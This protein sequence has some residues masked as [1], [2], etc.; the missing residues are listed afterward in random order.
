[1]LKRK[2]W[3]VVELEIL[4]RYYPDMITRAIADALG[5]TERQVYSKAASLGLKKSAEYLAGP[6]ACRLRRGDNVGAATRFKK[7]QT[8]WN[9]GKPG[10]TG[11]HPNSRRTQFKKGSMSGA[12]QHNYVPI[13]SLRITKDGYLERK[14]TDDPNLYPA[15]RWV[16]LHRLV[17]EE[18]HGP[19]PAGHLVVFRPGMKTTEPGEVTLDRL[20]CI[21][22]AENMRRNSYH[23]YPKEI[24]QAIQMR[25]ALNRKI[26]NVEKHQRSA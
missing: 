7:G 9:K 1:M 12:A 23:N 22:R 8:P 6:H 19:V 18:A 25:G 24:A 11:S 3:T 10:S 4:R 14:I 17:W 15:R 13:G 26:R 16:A 20:E 21:T 2:P 5:R